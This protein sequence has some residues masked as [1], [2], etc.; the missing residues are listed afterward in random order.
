MGRYRRQGRN[1]K[2]EF[3]VRDE[4][5]LCS[6]EENRG[7]KAISWRGRLTSED[8]SKGGEDVAKSTAS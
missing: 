7:G 4:G 5:K 6:R 3:R 8:R 1:R 2:G